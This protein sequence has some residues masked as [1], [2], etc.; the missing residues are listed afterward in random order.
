MARTRRRNG[1][2]TPQESLGAYQN[3]PAPAEI[4]EAKG[5]LDAA[6]GVN[7]NQGE[8]IVD[9]RSRL[10][11]AEL[12]IANYGDLIPDL[13]QR[14]VGMEQSA[15]NQALAIQ[16]AN[17]EIATLKAQMNNVLNALQGKSATTH[18]HDGVYLGVGHAGPPAHHAH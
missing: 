13:R 11:A 2:P 10:Q 16:D 4:S 18:D 12:K 5:R 7:G 8:L 9:L 14:M 17:Q 15:Q 3:S 6:E 1:A